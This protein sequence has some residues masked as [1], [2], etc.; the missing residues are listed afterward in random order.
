MSKKY[1]C[2]HRVDWS[3]IASNNYIWQDQ[4]KQE[5]I[6]R[7]RVTLRDCIVYITI[8]WRHYLV[9]VRIVYFLSSSKTSFLSVSHIYSLSKSNLVQSHWTMVNSACKKCKFMSTVVVLPKWQVSVFYCVILT[10]ISW[11]SKVGK[12]TPPPLQGTCNCTLAALLET[13]NIQLPANIFQGN[14]F[15]AVTCQCQ[16]IIIVPTV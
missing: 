14:Q 2:S 16:K 5:S 9:K 4:K 3:N 1:F 10:T 13:N 15:Q 8:A 6:K 11:C 7:N 12:L